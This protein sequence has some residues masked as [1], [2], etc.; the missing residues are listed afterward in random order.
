MCKFHHDVALDVARRA[1]GSIDPMA[2]ALN[3][4]ALG[5]NCSIKY[6]MPTMKGVKGSMTYRLASKEC[7][8]AFE[9]SE[10]VYDPNAFTAY[11]ANTLAFLKDKTN[12]SIMD[13]GFDQQR[14]AVIK[15]RFKSFLQVAP[16]EL[17]LPFNTLSPD[18]FQTPKQATQYQTLRLAAADYW[19]R[20]G[21]AETL[22]E[23]FKQSVTTLFSEAP[24]KTNPYLLKTYEAMPPKLK[25][26][27]ECAGGM[28]ASAGGTIAGHLGCIAKLAILPALGASSG[29]AH[30]PTIMYGMMA[31]GTA[32]GIGAWQLLHYQRGTLP[33]KM[34]KWATYGT[35]VISLSALM[36]WHAFGDGHD[37]HHGFAKPS[38]V[39]Y[40]NDEAGRSFMV[41]KN[42]LCAP[43]NN[44]PL[45]DTIQISGPKPT[46]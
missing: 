2:F 13:F 1:D 14:P 5:A 19:H 20:D 33:G 21:V 12:N 15:N 34:E 10:L 26:F 43:D 27:S 35:A 3:I 44:Q 9:Q 28:C 42:I 24:E 6:Y 16:D 22:T 31:G 39:T 17:Y 45:M 30:D 11:Q 7:Q 40:F 4:I 41:R 29:I 25:Q 23:R 8:T 32:L 18:V 46:L 36:S 37:H 38:S